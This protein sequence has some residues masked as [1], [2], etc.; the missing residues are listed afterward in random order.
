M[1]HPE[2]VKR[3]FTKPDAEVLQQSDVLFDSFQE[4]K[5]LHKQKPIFRRKLRLVG[6]FVFGAGWVCMGIRQFG[7][8]T[9]CRDQQT[10]HTQSIR[11]F[12]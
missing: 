1:E 6:F 8:V 5:S 12:A 11:A 9:T 3:T 2:E 7:S 4:N 10:N